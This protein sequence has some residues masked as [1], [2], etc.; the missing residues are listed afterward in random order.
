MAFH[1][2]ENNFLRDQRKKFEKLILE[3]EKQVTSMQKTKKRIE[4]DVLHKNQ[5]LSVEES[6]ASID[7]NT[8]KLEVG[9]KKRKKR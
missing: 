5:A 8:C 2:Q 9:P 1:L 7:V 6:C 3:L 4:T